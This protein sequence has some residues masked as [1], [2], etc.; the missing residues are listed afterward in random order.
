MPQSSIMPWLRQQRSQIPTG[1]AGG[2][3][4][5]GGMGL[6]GYGQQRSGYGGRHIIPND[7]GGDQGPGPVWGAKKKMEEMKDATQ[8]AR[9]A[10]TASFEKM[11]AAADENK[12]M[13]KVQ[14][15][16]DHLLKF[17]ESVKEFGPEG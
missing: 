7:L 11:A 12:F 5:L 3:A 16:Q 17:A 6:G 9:D 2:P 13:I 14:L 15:M 1:P 4:G 10:M 8:E